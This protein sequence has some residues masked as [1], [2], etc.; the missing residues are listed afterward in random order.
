MYAGTTKHILRKH[1]HLKNVDDGLGLIWPNIYMHTH[2]THMHIH[3]TLTTLA[4]AHGHN[5]LIATAN[6]S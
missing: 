3:T 2:H 1:H 6:E 5:E 4:H